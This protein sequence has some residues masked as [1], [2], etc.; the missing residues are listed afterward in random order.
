MCLKSATGGFTCTA[1]S[2]FNGGAEKI[3]TALT[4]GATMDPNTFNA[5]IFAL[6]L[7]RQVVV[8][9][10]TAS[11]VT[12]L[13]GTFVTLIYKIRKL[14][15]DSPLKLR[16]G[17]LIAIVFLVTSISFAVASAV[18]TPISVAALQLYQQVVE[19]AGGSVPAVRKGTALQA[20]EFTGVSFHVIFMYMAYFFILDGKPVS[21][22]GEFY[23]DRRY[24]GGGGG[25]GYDRD[26][27]EFRRDSRDY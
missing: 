7:Q 2:K 5:L 10:L 24:S 1:T 12:L 19:A 21:S 20:M 17:R 4:G 6:K 3:S 18:E 14:H 13:L 23:D 25:G 26:S 27:R 22:K 15:G 16:L 11:G 9:I 8:P